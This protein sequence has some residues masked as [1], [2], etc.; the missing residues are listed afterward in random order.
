MPFF[1]NSG[2]DLD[3]ERGPIWAAFATLRDQLERFVLLNLAWSIQI[4]PALAAVMLP[5]WPGVVRLVLFL[6][7]GIALAIATGLLYGLVW[8]AVEREPLSLEL[9]Q[10]EL[11]RL[12]LPGMRSLA[13]LYG[14]IGLALLAATW[15]S[16]GQTD[17]GASL[18]F[19][20]EVVAR[21]LL[22]VLLLCSMY[23]G[24]LFAHNPH[25][26][27]WAIARMSLRLIWQSPGRSLLLFGVVLVAGLIGAVSIGGVFLI[28]PVVIALLQ[29][30]MMRTFDRT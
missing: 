11:R 20:I 21:L 10:D 19:V 17:T 2:V 29:T 27:A 5:E 3:E 1:D 18:Y 15:S 14:L 12:A 16:T 26:P 23:W 30:H 9:A 7:S 13:P 8:A 25:T 6:Y 4:V 22:L 28:V 24:P